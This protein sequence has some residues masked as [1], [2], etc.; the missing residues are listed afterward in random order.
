MANNS[1]T[2]VTM[3]AFIDNSRAADA[4]NTV[5]TDHTRSTGSGGPG[6]NIRPTTTYDV[7]GACANHYAENT[8]Y[9]HLVATGKIPNEITSTEKIYADDINSLKNI[10][11]QIIIQWKL[12]D[13][14]TTITTTQTHTST[15]DALTS[16]T[17]IINLS[18]TPTGVINLSMWSNVVDKLSIIN[19][20]LGKSSLSLPSKD[21]KIKKDDYNIWVRQLIAITQACKCNSDCACNAVCVCNSDCGC[22]YSDINLKDN[23]EVIKPGLIDNIRPIKFKYKLPDKAKTDNRTYHYGIEAQS[24]LES[25]IKDSGALKK[26]QAGF[27]KVDYQEL[28]GILIAEV[29]ELKK[30]ISILKGK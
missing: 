2:S 9:N 7:Y 4:A 5:T 24:L 12:T 18:A 19:V 14:T 30:E 28:I 17:S 15:N 13:G 3:P 23:I 22:N 6:A 21:I 25:E 11:N 27:Y 1:I 20:K 26:D 8:I 10:I 16:T 29:Q